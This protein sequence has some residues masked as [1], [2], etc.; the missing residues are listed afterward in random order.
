MGEK[1]RSN[2][3]SSG[4]SRAPGPTVGGGWG[5]C[6]QLWVW[7]QESTRVQVGSGLVPAQLA[8]CATLGIHHPLGSVSLAV[9]LRMEA[10]AGARGP[11]GDLPAPYLQLLREPC[12]SRTLP[13]LCLSS[14]CSLIKK[15]LP[16]FLAPQSSNLQWCCSPDATFCDH[17]TPWSC[18][19]GLDSAAVAC[20][21]SPSPLEAP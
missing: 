19:M 6:C 21:L 9:E 4:Q 8:G 16:P 3:H 14:G 5:D 13:P 1:G 7:V 11:F 15:L 18:H 10:T 12:D 17:P 20:R 2:S